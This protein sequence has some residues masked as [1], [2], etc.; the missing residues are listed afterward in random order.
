[1]AENQDDTDL[2]FHSTSVGFS[3]PANLPTLHAYNYCNSLCILN[4]E[5][6]L[7][8]GVGNRYQ[9]SLSPCGRSSDIILTN[10]TVTVG[11]FQVF[12]L[13]VG[14]L[15]N[16]CCRTHELTLHID[17]FSTNCESSVVRA[18]KTAA[19]SPTYPTRNQPGLVAERPAAVVARLWGC[20]RQAVT[21]PASP[22]PDTAQDLLLELSPYHKQ[23]KAT[24]INARISLSFVEFPPSPFKVFGKPGSVCFG[25]CIF[26]GDVFDRG[27]RESLVLICCRQ[28]ECVNEI[29]VMRTFISSSSPCK[30]LILLESILRFNCLQPNPSLC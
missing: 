30:A 17:I 3:I 11:K 21:D 18:T 8:D 20:Q 9:E 7:T 13:G 25:C 27:A 15:V 2:L 6:F 16:P 5:F 23:L 29:K 1:M 12:Q 28:N 26:A 10:S 19:I 14:W 24:H 4:S 22:P